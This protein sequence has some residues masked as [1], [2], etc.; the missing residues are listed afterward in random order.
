[1]ISFHYVHLASDLL[2]KLLPLLEEARAFYQETYG[3]ELVIDLLETDMY[4][5]MEDG[6][7]I[8]CAGLKMG[9]NDELVY[10]FTTKEHRRKGLARKLVTDLLATTFKE[11]VLVTGTKQPEA[12]NLY[13]SLGFKEILHRD[14]TNIY[15]QKDER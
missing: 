9:H 11:V 2:D 12:Y 6:K 10:V 1:M 8:A 3:E 13:K 4:M 7:A 14:G 5:A 15:M